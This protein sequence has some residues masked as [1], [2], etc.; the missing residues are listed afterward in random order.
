MY[1][2]DENGI[3]LRNAKLI[4]ER[5]VRWFHTL[6]NAKSPSLDLKIAEGLNQ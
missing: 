4:R 2:K 3:L 6:L 5:W 1:T